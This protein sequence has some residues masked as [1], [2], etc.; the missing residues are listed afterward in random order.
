MRQDR[1]A[2][3]AI[4]PLRFGVSTQGELYDDAMTR[5]GFLL[6]L[7]SKHF[8]ERLAALPPQALEN[9]ATRINQ[10]I[11]HSLSAGTTLLALNAYITATRAD[12]DPQLGMSELLRNGVTV[13]PLQLPEGLMPKVQFSAAARGLRFTSGSDLNAFYLVNQSGFDRTPPHEALVKGFEILREYTDEAGHTLTQVRMGEQVGVHLKFR[14]IQDHT[15]VPAVALVDLLPGGFELVIPQAEA[16]PCSFC[17]GNGTANLSYADPRE[18]RVVFYSTLTSAVQEIVY[19]IKATNI[20]TY[21][22]PPAFGE[23]MYDRSLLA[24]SIAG[25]IEIV[26]P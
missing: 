5:D 8:P 17:S 18:D 22:I 23:A 20:G 7:L 19:R 24:R 4:A 6:Y 10:N 13:R 26:K 1:D 2:E 3:K 15:T 21:T 9:L 16:G 25:K 12:S 14:A 11:F